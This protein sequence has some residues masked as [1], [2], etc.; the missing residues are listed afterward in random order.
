MPH[1]ATGFV[2][3]SLLAFEIQLVVY[4]F[5][6]FTSVVSQVFLLSLLCLLIHMTS[7]SGNDFSASAGEAKLYLCSCEKCLS[8]NAGFPKD[9]SRSTYFRHKGNAFLASRQRFEPYAA[10]QTSSSRHS[11]WQTQTFGARASNLDKD[12]S[13]SGGTPSPGSTSGPDDS[14]P[15]WTGTMDDSPLRGSPN[16][17]EGPNG[18]QGFTEV[19]MQVSRPL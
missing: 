9:V 2:R 13:S 5:L 1:S 15:L 11:H 19:D 7:N 10:N 16:F 18:L 8:D 6:Y 3:F 17:D 14:P 12:I 4:L